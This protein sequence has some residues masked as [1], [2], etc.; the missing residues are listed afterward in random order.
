MVPCAFCGNEV[1]GHYRRVV[2]WE[3]VRRGGAGG[4]NRLVSRAETGEHACDACGYDLTHGMQ[5]GTAKLLD[6]APVEP[7]TTRRDH[8]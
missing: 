5:P 1:Q 7:I 3:K 2:G 6:V 8:A 4:L